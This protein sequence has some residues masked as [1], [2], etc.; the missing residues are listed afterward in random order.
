MVRADHRTLIPTEWFSES[1][2]RPKR[3]AYAG[4]LRR[5][6]RARLSWDTIAT[7]KVKSGVDRKGGSRL[8]G[9]PQAR[10]V[11]IQSPSCAGPLKEKVEQLGCWPKVSSPEGLQP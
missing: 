7:I 11:S 1:M 4:Q 5:N 10:Q 8:K 3:C 6:P 9:Y 2:D